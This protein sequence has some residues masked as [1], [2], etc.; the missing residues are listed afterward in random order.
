MEL[1]HLKRE[2]NKMYFW[3]TG[4]C[5]TVM[6]PIKRVLD[7]PRQHNVHIQ[8]EETNID[9]AFSRKVV[10]IPGVLCVYIWPAKQVHQSDHNSFSYVTLFPVRLGL[11]ENK[12]LNVCY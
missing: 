11:K 5:T 3:Y 1:I 4:V 10:I 9:D 6:C 8:Y 7:Y 2:Q 12:I